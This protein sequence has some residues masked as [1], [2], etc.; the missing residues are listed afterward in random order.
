[1]NSWTWEY[2]LND[3]YFMNHLLFATKAPSMK[4]AT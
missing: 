4:L 2:L 3:D 1:M